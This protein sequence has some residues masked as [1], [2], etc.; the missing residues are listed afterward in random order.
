MAGLEVVAEAIDSGNTQLVIPN[1]LYTEVLETGIGEAEFIN[2]ERFTQ[3][4]NIQVVDVN[5]VLAKTAQKLRDHAKRDSLRLD[6]VDS[7]FVAVG[8]HY[9]AQQLHTFD[10]RLLRLNGRFSL[11][12]EAQHLAIC[13]PGLSP[14]EPIALPGL[15][16]I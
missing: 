3:R 13:R 15:S 1:L 2:F 11:P 16:G 6:T 5:V 9:R 10:D 14:G 4:S 12:A 8:L 7:I